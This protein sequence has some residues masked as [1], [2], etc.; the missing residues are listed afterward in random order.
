ME[1]KK[2]SKQWESESYI[3]IIDPDGWD[4]TNFEYSFNEELITYDEFNN[5][6]LRSTIRWVNIPKTPHNEKERTFEEYK[7]VLS[8]ILERKVNMCKD[9]SDV[10]IK[11]LSKLYE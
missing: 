9:V 1:E 10:A 6:R 8:K 7:E 2:T 5:R 3:K 11:Y 4:R